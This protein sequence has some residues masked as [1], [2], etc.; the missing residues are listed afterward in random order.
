MD[1]QVSGA[2]EETQAISSSV[3][4]CFRAEER[5]IFK[6]SWLNK[7][8]HK[9]SNYR[10]ILENINPIGIMIRYNKLSIAIE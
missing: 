6:N 3:V 10:C 2:I 7:L 8:K 9:L 4:T 1:V 5:N